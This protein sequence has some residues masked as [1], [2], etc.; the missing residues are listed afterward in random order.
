VPGATSDTLSIASAALSQN[1]DEYEAVFSNGTSPDATTSPATLTVMNG[2]PFITTQ[3]MSQ[4]VYSGQDATFNAAASGFPTPTA[5]WQV[6]TDGGATFTNIA[7]ATTDTLTLSAVTLA[8]N[9]NLYRVVFTNS[10]GSGTS[11]SAALSV[12]P[13]VA[14]SVTTNP[15]DQTVYQGD[16][17]TFTAAAT[18]TPTPSVQWQISVDKGVTWVDVPGYTTTTIS[19]TSILFVNGWEFRAV[20]TNSG[21][22]VDTSAATL[23]VL[24]AIPPVVTLQPMSETVP[25]GGTDTFTAAATGT[26][27]PSVQWQISVDK[28]VTWIDVPGYTTTTISGVPILFVNGWEFRAVF[29]NAGGS[30]AT[31]GATLTITP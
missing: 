3:P 4:S 13:S 26:P 2:A 1:G 20:F 7:G 11:V 30:V 22:S 29:T 12:T 15:V 28:G 31:V 27:T 18:G 6:S 19:G 14:P 25:L 5:Q 23:T 24:P 9:G 16:T 17:D 10:F 8:E 21:G